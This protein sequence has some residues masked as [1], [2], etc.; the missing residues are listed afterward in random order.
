MKNEPEEG[1]GAFN[2]R[3]YSRRTGAV[4]G[5]LG[6]QEDQ[7]MIFNGGGNIKLEEGEPVWRSCWECNSSH[8]HLKNR[9]RV[10]EC[11]RCGKWWVAGIDFN[12]IESDE[13]FDAAFTSLGMKPGDST[14]GK[15]GEPGEVMVI[16]LGIGDK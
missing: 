14:I 15:I 5:R 10:H 12:K 11:T 4:R 9:D 13:A 8:G 3:I 1:D 16:Q 6:G 7:I 2:Q